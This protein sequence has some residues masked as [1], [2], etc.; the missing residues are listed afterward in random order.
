MWDRLAFS[1]LE[2]GDQKT[3]WKRDRTL[4]K[5]E[6]ETATQSS[7]FVLLKLIM[8]W[9]GIVAPEQRHLKSTATW[10]AVAPL[11]GLKKGW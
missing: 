5:A 2:V 7:T 8:K 11:F 3:L 1:S 6:N 9:N 4:K 10:H